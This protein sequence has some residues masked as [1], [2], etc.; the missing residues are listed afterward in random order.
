VVAVPAKGIDNHD[1]GALDEGVKVRLPAAAA[2]FCLLT[3]VGLAQDG[4]AWSVIEKSRGITVSRRVQ[5]GCA[6]P[7][8]R[9]QGNI[10]GNVLQVLAVM[11]D[12]KAVESWAHGVT[13]SR[14]IK[15]IDARTH[16]VYLHSDL[17]WPV[18]D[19]D[20]IV[21]SEVDVVKPA[22]EFRVT[23]HCE[24]TAQPE[25]DG[26]IRVQTCQSTLHLRKVD[27]NTTA[28]DYV[29]TLDPAGNLPSWSAE[30][31]T[32]ATPFKT[33]VALEER[34]KVSQGQ[35]TASVRSWAAAL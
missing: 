20:M 6:L 16:L 23:L 4:G 34:A 29:M 9:G 17:P 19:R 8:F 7:A 3:S 35:Y 26:V 27:E 30:W 33:L 22:E 18:K 21:R 12:L 24:P 2:L 10:H 15:R 13:E 28:V 25:L 14:P 11:L 32:K 31:V 5:A 1:R